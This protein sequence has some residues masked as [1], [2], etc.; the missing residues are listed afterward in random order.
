VA[1]DDVAAERLA[2]L[3]EL[4]GRHVVVTGAASGIGLA[5]SAGV[6]A[7]GGRLTLID[8]ESAA[9]DTATAD[10][11][12]EGDVVA[13]IP[14][15]VTSAADVYSA[16]AAA[17]SA[18][19]TITGLVNSAGIGRRS[20]AVDLTD[21]AWREVLDVNLSG[22]FKMCRA[23]GQKLI[24]AGVP[25]SIVNISSIAGQVGLRTGN[26]N[27]AASKGG[28]DALTRTL[29]V[30]GAAHQVRVNAIAPTHVRTPLVQRAIDE[31]PSRLDYFLGSIP[32]GRLG[33]PSDVV[34]SAVFL[35]ASASAM[36]TGHVLN[37]D[38]GHSI[39]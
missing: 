9:L 15:D 23:V 22:T 2:D 5:I 21:D 27:Y 8:R 17:E 10:L 16:I 32:L 30:E 1:D 29:A 35:L 39:S 33:R 6:L 26:A 11:G 37:V 24:A 7:F 19:G 36:I 20:P 14:A 28:V 3:F 31:D 25:G 13:A 18:G 4:S 38:G 34:G 12:A